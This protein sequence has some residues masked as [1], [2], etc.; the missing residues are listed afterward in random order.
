MGYV[1]CCQCLQILLRSSWYS[2][3]FI[4]YESIKEPSIEETY[5]DDTLIKAVTAL[6]PKYREVVLLYYYQEL[7]V[8]EI[9]HALSLTESAVCVRLNRA[10]KQLKDDLEGWYFNEELKE[11]Y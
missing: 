2:K 3:V 5:F 4:G 8:K 9:A 7:T 6:K 1:N 10:R 11:S